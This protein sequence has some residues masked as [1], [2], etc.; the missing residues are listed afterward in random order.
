MAVVPDFPIDQ[1]RTSRCYPGTEGVARHWPSRAGAASRRRPTLAAGEPKS[2]GCRRRGAPA[3][4]VPAGPWPTSTTEGAVSTPSAPGRWPAAAPTPPP[5]RPIGWNCSTTSARPAAS[6]RCASGAAGAFVL[7]F[8]FV[9]LVFEFFNRSGGPW[10]PYPRAPPPTFASRFRYW[11]LLI[12]RN[13]RKL[14]RR[15]WF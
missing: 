7:F 6:T 2:A 10:T 13:D 3:G 8:F 11:A 4:P 14:M 15:A 5:C 9:R 1:R 12:Y